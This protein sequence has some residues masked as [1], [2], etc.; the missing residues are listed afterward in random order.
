MIRDPALAHAVHFVFEWAALASGAWLYRH[1][2]AVRRAPG[3]MSA[4][5]F[6]VVLGCLVGAALGNKL[7]FWLEH[8][9]LWQLMAGNPSA[10]F[11]GQSV[12]GGLLGG[13]LG[14]EVG[15][16]F[17]P[18]R[19]RTGDDFVRPILLGLFVGRIGCFLAGLNDGTY[20]VPTTMPW[21]INFGDGIPR[22]A[23]QAYECVLALLAL[24]THA[25]WSRPFAAKPGLT[26]RV[27]MLGY[28][29]WRLLIDCL[30]PVPYHFVL[31]LSGI[32]LLCVL[33]IFLIGVC[34]LLDYLKKDEYADAGE[35]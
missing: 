10:W 32:Q 22:H 3:V 19:Q 4:H 5:A 31:G 15:K 7:A 2:R 11:M 28:L 27:L 30:K 29:L 21:G 17:A 25:Q 12:V 23:T 16:W 35:K 18:T 8:P 6:P 20:G 9:H 13:W 1:Q 14:V 26:F 34:M 24:C 33:A